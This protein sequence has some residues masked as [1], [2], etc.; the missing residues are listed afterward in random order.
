MTE[1]GI[2]TDVRLVHPLK[3]LTPMEVTVSGITT[4]PLASGVYR[5]PPPDV[6]GEVV[7]VNDGCPVEGARVGDGLRGTVGL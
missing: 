1:L 2:T 4:L 5:Q 6:A 7:G 3:A